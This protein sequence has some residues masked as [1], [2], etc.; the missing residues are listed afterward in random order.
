MA[1]KVYEFA[2]TNPPLAKLA[3]PLDR[4]V[5]KDSSHLFSFS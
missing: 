4:G 3:P 5:A 2:K 1:I